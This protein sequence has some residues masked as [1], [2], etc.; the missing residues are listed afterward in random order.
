MESLRLRDIISEEVGNVLWR[1]TLIIHCSDYGS[2]LSLIPN[3]DV[4]CAKQMRVEL[5]SLI[6][7]RLHFC[8]VTKLCGCEDKNVVCNAEKV[9]VKYS[10]A[11]Y[12]GH[13]VQEFVQFE[14]KDL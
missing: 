7:C 11:D 10:M 14:I 12:Q 9:L 6:K 5:S 2:V 13:E 3:H 8:I 4:E 1:G